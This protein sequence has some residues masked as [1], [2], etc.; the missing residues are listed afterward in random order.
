M[1]LQH[2]YSRILTQTDFDELN[3][4]YNLELD[5]FTASDYRHAQVIWNLHCKVEEQ[6]REIQNLKRKTHKMI[7]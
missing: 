4:Q 3:S 6:D 1:S 2:K 5:F 7:D